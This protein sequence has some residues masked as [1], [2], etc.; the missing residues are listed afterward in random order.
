[1]RV[2]PATENALPKE[3]I[4]WR[5]Q[6]DIRKLRALE[7]YLIPQRCTPDDGSDGEIG[8]S[9]LNDLEP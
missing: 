7:H 8:V 4:P 5:E 3:R 1:M 9:L 2:V 6:G